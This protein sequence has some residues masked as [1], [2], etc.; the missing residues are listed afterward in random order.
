MLLHR[1]DHG[2]PLR[3]AMEAAGLTGPDLAKR[4][5][6]VDP[7]GRGV[8]PAVVGFLTSTGRSGRDRCRIRTAWLIATGVNAPLQELFSMPPASTSTD[9]R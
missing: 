8:S 6:E 5:R 4:T 3:R 9:E 7:E 2:R 1:L